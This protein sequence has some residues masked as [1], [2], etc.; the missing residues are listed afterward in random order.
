MKHGETAKQHTTL[1]FT[2]EMTDQ[3]MRADPQ[4]RKAY[5]THIRMGGLG[6]SN[7]EVSSGVILMRL[8]TLAFSSY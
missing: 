3:V 1:A 6:K 5:S 4:L 7:K 2:E 8:T